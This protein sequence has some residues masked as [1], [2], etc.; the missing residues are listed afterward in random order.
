MYY[1]AVVC[2]VSVNKK[3]LEHKKWMKEQ[4][5]CVV[6]LKSPAHITL[7]PPFWMEEIKEAD[8]VTATHDFKTDINPISIQLNGFSH[9]GDRVLLITVI[10]NPQ[11]SQLKN[12]IEKHFNSV[13]PFIKK[14]EKP[15]HPHITIANRDMKPSVFI[16][17]WQHFSKLAFE[18]SFNCADISLLKLK[19]GRWQVIA[20]TNLV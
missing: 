13:F 14:G 6:A 12:E 1:V 10:D 7:I 16:K 3:V 2:P 18:E 5:G 8:L 15:F 11:L 19:E 17:A 20:K 9:F 4:F